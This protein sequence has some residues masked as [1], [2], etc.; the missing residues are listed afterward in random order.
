[1][2]T[3]DISWSQ[4]RLGFKE[5]QGR[6]AAR[7]SRRFRTATADA[8]ALRSAAR[9]RWLLRGNARSGAQLRSHFPLDSWN[10]TALLASEAL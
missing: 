10:E 5:T 1:L 6:I 9:A 2:V 8:C 7:A 3:V 4:M